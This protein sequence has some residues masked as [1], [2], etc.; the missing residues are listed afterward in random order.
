MMKCSWPSSSSVRKVCLV[1][2]EE[3]V[4]PE[5][6]RQPGFSLVVE[7]GGEQMKSGLS[8]AEV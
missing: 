7:F 2:E 8:P 1:P 6:T 4:W 5:P 3:P